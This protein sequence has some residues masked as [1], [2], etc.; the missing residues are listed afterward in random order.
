VL[1]SHGP[2]IDLDVLRTLADPLRLRIVRLLAAE[3][4]CTCHLVDMTGARQTNVSNHLRMLRQAGLV[5]AEP[6]GRY[7]YYRLSP[8]ALKTLAVHLGDLAEAARS[9]TADD[10]RRPCP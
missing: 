8:D 10:R 1:T 3:A 5:R 9:V 4:L 7:T 6:H 2:D